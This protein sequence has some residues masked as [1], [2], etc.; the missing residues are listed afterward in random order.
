MNLSPDDVKLFY[1]LFP[2]LL[3]FVN[4]RHRIEGV[5]TDDQLM[6][7]PAERR[8]AIREKLYQNN[9]L[10][11]EFVHS[12][13]RQFTSEEL[14]IVQGWKSYLKGQFYLVKQLKKHPIFLE[15]DQEA[16]AYGV[17]AIADLFSEL[18]PFIPIIVETVL[19]PFKGQIIYDGL[20]SSRSIYLGAGIK[21]S[22]N[23]GY[24]E[25][26]A[27]YGVITSLSD[28]TPVAK[29]KSDTQLLKS[30]L[31]SKANRA[32]HWEEIQD[33]IRKSEENNT[34]YYQEIGKYY[35]KQHRKRLRE[36]GICNGW[37]GIL[38][39]VIIGSGTTRKEAES[40]IE[41]IVSKN[42]LKHVYLFQ[43]VGKQS[44]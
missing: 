21:R 1:K 16:K 18:V 14:V 40:N 22:L 8:F 23:N 32:K 4:E 30:F 35:A 19:I 43:L 33:L 17:L 12:N 24:N 13:P 5:T 9:Y 28:A 3:L 15:F 44:S 11:D 29:S 7:L 42:R 39:N 27:K 20:I 2:A 6:S 26:K 10:I 37:F 41:N 25:A 38:E 31:S 36:L 34:F